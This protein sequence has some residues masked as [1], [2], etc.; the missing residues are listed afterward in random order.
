MN[1]TPL[2]QEELNE[3]IDLAFE[4][5]GEVIPENVRLIKSQLNKIYETNNQDLQLTWVCFLALMHHIV[6][7]CSPNFGVSVSDLI[8]SLK[9]YE[10]ARLKSIEDGTAQCETINP[11]DTDQKH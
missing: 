7:N 10:R 8:D 4:L 11:N 5:A 2:S 9:T 3:K 6:I 1:N